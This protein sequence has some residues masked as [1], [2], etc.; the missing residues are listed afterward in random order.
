MK[1]EVIAGLDIGTSSLKV[2]I[3]DCEFGSILDNYRINYN[4][5]YFLKNFGVTK[6]IMY[7]EALN[8]ALNI[9]DDKYELKA[10]GLSTQMYS[11]CE[12][13]EE[14]IIIHQWNSI[15]NRDI[16]LEKELKYF[17]KNSGCPVDTLYPAY[18]LAKMNKKPK[19]RFLPYGLKEHLIK[20]L[21]GRLVTD[22]TCASAS[23]L[24]DIYKRDWNMEFIHALGFQRKD[25]PEIIQHNKVIDYIMLP[26]KASGKRIALSSGLGD[27]PSASYACIDLGRICVNI[28][29]SMAARAIVDTLKGDYEGK[30]W[31]YNL[32]S[33]RFIMGGISSNGC[34]VLNW[35]VGN[36]FLNDKDIDKDTKGVMFFP[37]F[38]GERTP[39]WSSELKGT[40]TGITLDTDMEILNNAIIKGVAFTAARLINIV[41]GNT[42]GKKLAIIAGGGSH[43]KA[44]MKVLTGSISV[45]IGIINDC[46]YLAS[47]GAVI[48]ASEAVDVKLNNYLKLDYIIEHNDRFKEEY[49]RWLEMSEKLKKIYED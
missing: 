30:P 22:F 6:A 38:H 2:T 42:E 24:M 49:C 9:I 1:K 27:G 23:G 5:K 25:L 43:S 35:A 10:V 20:F 4:E 36:K 19:R 47:L 44:L 18:K 11:L 15:W 12:E 39:Y 17:M 29:T 33:S 48:S 41:S 3:V 16:E 26:G 31:V 37:W 8:N 28:G 21:S 14:G 13:T 34:S 45:D 7:E 46:D 40:F 32:D